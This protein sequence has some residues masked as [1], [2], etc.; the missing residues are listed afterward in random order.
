MDRYAGSGCASRSGWRRGSAFA[1]VFGP[2]R[3]VNAAARTQA[4][5]PSRSAGVTLYRHWPQRLDLLRD[6]ITEEVHLLHTVP[7]GDVRADLMAEPT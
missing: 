6:L 2:R 3:P 7:T 5:V 4:A 1:A